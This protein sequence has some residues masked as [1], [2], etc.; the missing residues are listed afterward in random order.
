MSGLLAALRSAV[1]VL[2]M[3][4]T[5]IPWALAVLAA[6]VFVRGAPLYWMCVGWLRVVIWGARWI[7]GVRHRVQGLEHLPTA[8]QGRE[9]VLLAPKHQST[10]ETFALPT[11]MPHPLAYVF[12]R[13]LLMIPFFG[14]AMGR[15]DMIH[16]DRSKRTEAW[17]KV[18]EQ[19]RRLMA[20]GVWVIMFPEGT[21][22]P[23][24]GQGTYKTGAARLAIATGT[25]IVPIAVTSAK[26]WPRKSFLLRP[27]VIDVSIGRPIAVQGREPDELMRDIEHWIE[28]EMRRLDPEAYVTG[29]AGA[30]SS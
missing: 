18:A 29:A 28:A 16:I 14:W 17:H 24:G 13:E 21:R 26:C 15:L 19:G 2:F 30:A 8:A 5:V 4:V 27:G 11:I 23:R 9:A 25:P 3:T 7:C 1:F 12:K 10:W 22:T 20:E 6:S